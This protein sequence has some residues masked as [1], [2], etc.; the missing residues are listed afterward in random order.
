MKFRTFRKTMGLMLG[1]IVIAGLTT[2]C[3]H[4]MSNRSATNAPATSA[5]PM[6][7]MDHGPMSGGM[8]HAG[9]ELGTADA[10]YDLRFIDGMMPHHAGALTMA[11]SVLQNSQR[12]ELKKLANAIISGQT[13]EIATMQQWR[14]TWYPKQSATPMAWH[15][16]MQHMM[17]MAPEQIKAMRMDMDLGKAD[18]DF[19]RRFLEA[20]IPHHEGA[21]VMAQDAL[22]KSKRPEVQKMAK[23]IIAS[24]QA[25]IDQMKQWRKDWY[26]K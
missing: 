4:M 24:Q 9:M 3:N 8:S 15:S 1:T 5:S 17:P 19:D 2:S 11:Q 25:E 16:G 26:G 7:Q 23:D 10:D 13:Q 18:A 21:V 22:A 6:S 14:K 20:M 12:P